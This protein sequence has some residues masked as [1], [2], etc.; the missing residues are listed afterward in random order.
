MLE[1][2]DYFTENLSRGF[3]VG[4]LGKSEAKARELPKTE[5]A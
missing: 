5:K 1:D 2:I 3:F 4:K